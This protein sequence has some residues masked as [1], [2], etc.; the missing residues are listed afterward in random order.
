MVSQL[1]GMCVPKTWLVICSMDMAL[2]PEFKYK[3][4]SS[5]QPFKSA[6]EKTQANQSIIQTPRQQMVDMSKRQDAYESVCVREK[7]NHCI[8]KSRKMSNASLQMP[9]PALI[10]V[11]SCKKSCN[12]RSI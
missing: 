8:P 9:T 7:R 6:P 3:P 1:N 4:D 2:P 10:V 11:L 5:K 12:T